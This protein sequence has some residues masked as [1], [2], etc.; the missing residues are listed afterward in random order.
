MR[1]RPISESARSHPAQPAARRLTST[2]RTTNTTHRARNVRPCDHAATPRHAGDP[3]A[4]GDG[5][6]ARSASRAVAV[7]LG[8]RMPQ[9][10]P[11]CATGARPSESKLTPRSPAQ[12]SIS[13]SARA[14]PP[15]RVRGRHDAASD[16]VA[17]TPRSERA[18]SSRLPRGSGRAEPRACVA[19]CRCS[20][21][22]TRPSETTTRRAHT[23]STRRS[24][25]AGRPCPAHTGGAVGDRAS[26]AGSSAPRFPA[27]IG[28]WRPHRLAQP[29]ASVRRRILAQ[30]PLGPHRPLPGL[31]LPARRTAA[32]ASAR[33]AHADL[34]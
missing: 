28:A 11:P 12:A 20:C 29:S 3:R 17:R 18:A 5:Q 15:A 31:A 23:C 19:L 14:E 8:A 13:P 21:S 22:S 27:S 26:T 6:V 24:V 7:P 1:R 4:A 10:H 33:G 34:I 2:Q 32:K 30:P 9:V 25:P 16:A